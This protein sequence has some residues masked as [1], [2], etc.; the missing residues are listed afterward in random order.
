MRKQ[1]LLGSTALVVGALAAPDFA[2]AEEPLRL[3]VRGYKNEYFVIG[4]VDDSPVKGAGRDFSNTGEFSDGEVQFRGE[5]ALDNGLTVGVYVELE[6]NSAGD[7]IDEN[8]IF[9]KGDFGK[10]VMGSENLSNYNTFWG[11]VAPNVGTPINSGWITVFV[12]APAGSDLGFRSPGLSTNITVGNDENSVSY[13][14][15][16]FG[17]FQFTA[18]YAPAV[19]DSGDGKTYGGIEANE[20]SEYSNGWGV[21]LNLSN[22]FNGVD[23]S[24]AVA[25][26]GISVPD[27]RAALGADDVE[28]FKAGLGLGFGGF[29]IGGS[30]ANESEGKTSITSKT[31][32][33]YKKTG[34]GGLVF[35]DDDNNGVP[36]TSKTY[37]LNSNEG[38]S[39]DVGVSYSTGPW[40]VSA[41]YFHGEEEGDTTVSGDDE[42]DAILGAVRY[43][44]GPGI[45]TSLSIMHVKFEEESG[46]ETE[47]TL[48]IVG[49][50]VKF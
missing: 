49:L 35:V 6:S 18:G 12:P 40:G 22:S 33:L 50:S 26:N 25:Y 46:G 7:Q 30:Y 17:G 48:G 11:V 37:S 3:Q 4:D 20:G 1:L 23:I 2:A 44:L 14:S 21:G 28:Q 9:V 24:A 29:S 34:G 13:Y 47:A 36:D 8:F 41:T 42:I 43:T 39:Y 45:T 15:P 38:Q 16:R 31:T 19:V 27:D 10:I 5:T 32:P